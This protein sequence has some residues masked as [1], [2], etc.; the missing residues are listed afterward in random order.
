MLA[1]GER[2]ICLAAADD[3]LNENETDESAHKSRSWLNQSVTTRQLQFLPPEYRQDFGLTRY[4]ASALLTFQFNKAA[5]TN[6]V[7][8]APDGDRRAA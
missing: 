7:L 6:L 4:Q 3:W 1:M 5:I 2:T 8:N